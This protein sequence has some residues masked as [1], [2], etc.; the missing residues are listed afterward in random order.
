MKIDQVFVKGAHTSA[1]DRT[2]LKSTI[3][4]AHNLGM[5]VTAEGVEDDDI[6]MA[7]RVMGCDVAQGYGLSKALPLDQLR[8]FLDQ[9]CSEPARNV[10]GSSG[11][12]TQ[13]RGR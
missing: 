6:L 9:A 8:Q 1:K 3:D 11:S 13:F 10:P 4:L 2:L 5:S 7:L 12:I